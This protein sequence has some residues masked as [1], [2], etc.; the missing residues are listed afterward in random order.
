MRELSLDWLSFTYIPDV[1]RL[2]SIDSESDLDIVDLFIRDFPELRDI[3]LEHMVNIG[4]KMHYNT[5]LKFNDDFL[6]LYNDLEKAVDDNA[7]SHLARMGLNFIVP[8]HSLDLFF[9][10]MGFEKN[11]LQEM[12]CL[13][14]SR[15]CQL[16]RIDLCYDDYDKKY[17]PMFYFDMWRSGRIRSNF[18]NV[19]LIGTGKDAGNTLYL[20][21]MKKRNKL[22]R[23][24][25]KD[26]ESKGEKDCVRYE[27]E[28]HAEKARDMA[29]YIIDNGT[30]DFISYLRSWFEVL[31]EHCNTT[32]KSMV[33]TLSEWIDYFSESVFCEKI[34]IPMYDEHD[35]EKSITRFIDRQVLPSLKGYIALYGWN[36]VKNV[37]DSVEMNPNYEGYIKSLDYRGRLF[38]PCLHSPFDN[39]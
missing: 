33:S 5:C 32:N 28:L 35:R 10:I 25:D 3:V 2:H 30:L 36:Y 39:I 22:L 7:I 18:E 27:F 24:Y 1:A 31:V 16:S 20:G 17:R 34:V 9:S 11:D 38:T 6:L 4:G 15:S 8:S 23:I 26:I 12:I 14:Y 13:L 37:L 21:S 29:Q 19:Q